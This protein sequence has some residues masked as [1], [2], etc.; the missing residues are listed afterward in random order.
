MG[1]ARRAGRRRGLPGPD[2][3]GGRTPGR[4]A[5]GHAPGI[6]SEAGG[7]QAVFEEA[8]DPGVERYWRL[9]WIVNGWQV[10]ADLLPPHPGTR[11]GPDG[12]A[13]AR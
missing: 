6:E 10:V 1:G 7:E 13:D 5:A 2:A 8:H 3:P 4:R 11:P 12:R 9:V